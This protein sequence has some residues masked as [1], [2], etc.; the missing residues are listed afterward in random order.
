MSWACVLGCAG[1]DADDDRNPTCVAAGT[2]V[3]APPGAVRIESIR[4][5]TVVFA[6]DP[7][8]GE[9]VA[10]EVTAVR[11]ARRE[12]IRLVA[13]GTALICTP[14]HPLYDPDAAVYAPASDW[15]EGKR[16]RLCLVDTT[17]T[18]IRAVDS[19]QAYAGVYDVYDITVA[20]E[21]HNFIADGILAHN[22]SPGCITGDTWCGSGEGDGT[23]A[24]EPMTGV[25]S[26]VNDSTTGTGTDTDTDTDTDFTG[27]GTTTEDASTSG[28][29]TKGSTETSGGTSSGSG[30]ST[31][32]G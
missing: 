28:T 18:R 29:T 27:S 2:R 9:R 13:G 31:S 26:N 12:C 25:V 3:G 7:G 32:T 11:K 21:L 6:V 8:T 23:T 4:P 24:S 15:V 14:D 16:G 20:H 10:T 30:S 1:G 17:G 5:G 22:K 19:V